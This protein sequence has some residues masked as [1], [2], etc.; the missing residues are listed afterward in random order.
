MGKLIRPFL[1][2][3]LTGCALTNP[4]D[5]YAPVRGRYR[6]TAPGPPLVAGV[7]A[8]R[9]SRPLNLDDCV[10]IALENNPQ[11]GA[12]SWDVGA[13]EAQ[14]DA[15]SA[16][17]WPALR[18]VGG[19]RHHLDDQRLLAAREPNEPGVW[20]SDILS[21]DLVLSMP[22]FTGGRIVNEIWAAEL[23]ERAAS[24][25]LARTKGE[26]VFNVSSTFYAIL[27][28]RRVI[29][30]LEFS[31]TALEEHRKRVQDL[32]AVQKA[33][34]VDLLRTEVRVADLEQQ[35]VRERNTLAIQRRVLANLMGIPEE[36]PS[37]DVA[38]ELER[39]ETPAGLTGNLAV[40]LDQ[41]DDYEAARRELEAQ[42]KRVDAARAGYWPTVSL[43]AAYGGRWAAGDVNRQPGADRS[44]EVSSV[45]VSASIPLFEGG[46]IEA[47]VRRE[48]ARLAS[49][50]ESLRKL[51]LQIGL[52]VQTAVLNVTSS[53][54][55]V[56]AV[57]KAIEQARES[58]RIER[59]KYDLGKG[60]ITDVLDAQ[61]ALLEAERNYARALAEYHT[62]LAQYR[63]AMGETP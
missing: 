5:P 29:E 60:S 50:Q 58:L 19:Y 40:A 3:I 25:R 63:L 24:H 12:Q 21:A 46:R 28:Q 7:L 16:Q 38:G 8:E 45:G 15:A 48:K 22:I 2:V 34:R 31:H 30:S 56:R 32:I 9:L 47:G 54:Q 1:L 49:A 36:G 61:S 57:E 4:T 43:D 27:G 35:L 39:P 23:L 51:E 37:L 26:L 52:E 20:S 42:A 55:R 6:G 59:E 13:A 11:I 53:M 18:A 10:Q 44:E 17:R 62:A 33:A 14:T 41:R